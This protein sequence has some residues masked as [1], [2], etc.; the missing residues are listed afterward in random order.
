M[1]T[2]E[3]FDLKRFGKYF[4]SDLKTLWSNFGL[5]LM[6]T[7]LALP[8]VIYIIS[9]AFNKV[10]NNTWCGPSMDLRLFVFAMAM[11]CIIVT[12]PVKCY[13]RITEKQYGSFWITLPA[14]RLEKYL[15]MIILTC[16]IVPLAGAFLCLGMDAITCAI[17]HSC[18]SS[19]ISS[20]IDMI[21]KME[22]NR[23]I[24]IN[25]MN[26]SLEIRDAEVVR[27]IVNQFS[28]PWLYIDEIFGITLPILLGAIFFKRGKTAK[29]FLS[30]FALGSIFSMMM[31][32]IMVNWTKD[33]MSAVGSEDPELVLA[34]FDSGIFRNMVII[35]T[36]SDTIFN[37]A[38]L[39][40][41]WFRIK[42]LKH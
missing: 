38:L 12:M 26:E 9:I 21:R 28:S 16:I 37:S 24:T 30:L 14:S 19:I 39:L 36:I 7:S 10:I 40:G 8:L 23:E 2:N 34:I 41:I 18:G 27:N 4:G 22:E 6:T 15:S 42:T 25:L 17:D 32:P 29:T 1:K 13:G 20:G 11:F 5:S 3:I 35:D 31:T 33:I